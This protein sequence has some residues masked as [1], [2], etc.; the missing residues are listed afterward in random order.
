MGMDAIKE[1]PNETRRSPGRIALQNFFFFA[2]W[3]IA[4]MSVRELHRAGHPVSGII[5]AGMVQ[6]AIF[7]A[8]MYIYRRRI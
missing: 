5:V 1:A 7:T 6:G 2:F 8:L 3:T 4:W